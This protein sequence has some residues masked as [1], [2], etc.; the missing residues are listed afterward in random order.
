M[1]LISTIRSVGV[2]EELLGEIIVFF[3]QFTRP[4]SELIY[5]VTDLVHVYISFYISWQQS[6]LLLV[7]VLENSVSNVCFKKNLNLEP[8]NTSRKATSLFFSK[9]TIIN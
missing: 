8:E 4:E 3:C 9:K 6:D 1:Q 7:S 5:V 2:S